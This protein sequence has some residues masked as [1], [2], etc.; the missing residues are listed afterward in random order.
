MS[1]QKTL[2]PKH[3]STSSRHHRASSWAGGGLRAAR[4][5]CPAARRAQARRRRSAAGSAAAPRAAARPAGIRCTRPARASRR[6]AGWP[7]S[8]RRPQTAQLG[9]ARRSLRKRSV[10]Q[11][12]SALLKGRAAEARCR[13]GLLVWLPLLRRDCAGKSAGHCGRRPAAGCLSMA[14][15]R[16]DMHGTSA[17]APP[18]E[19]APAS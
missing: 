6:G 18:G 2:W 11:G 17:A 16:R 8:P 4:R 14:S 3:S 5:S 12:L 13:A 15:V 1:P 19:G 9:S 10:F 7:R